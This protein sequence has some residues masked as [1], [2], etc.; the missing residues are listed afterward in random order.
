MTTL[1]TLT[2]RT[3]PLGLSWLEAKVYD[4]LPSAG[5]VGVAELCRSIE[6]TEPGYRSTTS[7]VSRTVTELARRGIAAGEKTGGG[8]RW[9]RAQVPGV[10]AVSDEERSTRSAALADLTSRQRAAL[11]TIERDQPCSAAS[12][13]R[14]IDCPDRQMR[15]VLGELQSRGLVDTNGAG[16]WQTTN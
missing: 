10:R 1:T 15:F 13:A 5:S 8:W 2:D 4:S 11:R 3:R 7:S 14:A 12:V 9:R 16:L 6:A